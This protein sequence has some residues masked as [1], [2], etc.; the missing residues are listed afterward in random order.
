MP[1]PTWGL[2]QQRSEDCDVVVGRERR[3]SEEEAVL[4]TVGN[5]HGRVKLRKEEVVVM[6]DVAKLRGCN[7]V[8]VA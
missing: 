2:V 3:R 6:Q 7:V 8:L 1:G 5:A 4:D